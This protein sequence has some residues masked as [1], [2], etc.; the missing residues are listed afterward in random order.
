MLL[1]IG[2]DVGSTTSK[3]IVL[4]EDG[5]IVYQQYLRH[6]SDVKNTTNQMLK[7][8]VSLYPNAEVTMSISGSAGISMAKQVR[9]PFIQE[10]IA[11]TEAVEKNIPQTDVVIE[12]GG[13]DAKIIYFSNGIEQRMNAACAGGTGAFIDQI[14]ALIQ[15]DAKG[16]NELAMSYQKIYPIASR[17]G[18]FE[19]T[20]VQP[21]LN[22]GARKEDIAASVFQSV[23]TQTVS[24][25]ACGRPIKGKVAFL[26]GPLTYLSELRLRFI[27]TLKLS[28]NE[29]IFPSN[30]QYYVAIGT[31]M[32]SKKNEVLNLAELCKR[33]E[34]FSLTISNTEITKL[35]C[36]FRDEQE[37]KEFRARHDQA[38]VKT[39][40]LNLYKGASYLGIDAGST[41]TKIVLMGENQELLYTF[42]E[43]NKGNPLQSVLEG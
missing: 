1:H 37:L 38:T 24:G 41:T 19:K 8:L 30:S 29:V 42:Y 6:F 43:S 33:F 23:V 26:G 5:D 7:E 13:E 12:L 9:I 34:G 17:C 32:C 3:I 27:E 28:N 36:L 22:E 2:L 31:A 25:L 10:V 4:N 15:T 14:A 40:D 35:P 18:V 21:L 16:L 11:C 39:E 20:D